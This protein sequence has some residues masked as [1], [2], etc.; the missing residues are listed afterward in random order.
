ML[1]LHTL[2]SWTLTKICSVILTP[3]QKREGNIL[4]C[5][6]WW[7]GR[8]EEISWWGPTCWHACCYLHFENWQIIEKN[9]HV[10]SLRGSRLESQRKPRLWRRPGAP[11][12]VT[13][14]SRTV[15]K[16][17]LCVLLGWCHSST[18]YSG[19]PAHPFPQWGWLCNCK[20]Y[21]KLIC[22]CAFWSLGEQT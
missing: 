21:Q 3:L 4:N 11:S 12:L 7:S 20:N 18:P 22:L 14:C 2:G 1:P 13:E 5:T 17:V 8:L 6:R 19:P 9:Q 10:K 15:I 16:Q